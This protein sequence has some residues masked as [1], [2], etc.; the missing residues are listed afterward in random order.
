[1]QEII[2]ELTAGFM[3]DSDK[4]L[5]RMPAEIVLPATDVSDLKVGQPVFLAACGIGKVAA[6]DGGDVTVR[7]A[8]TEKK[9]SA[10]ALVTR[11]QAE[12]NWRA[13]WLP[14]AE[15]R[16]EEGRRLWIVKELCTY[17][18]WQDFLDRFDLSRSTCDDLIRR[19]KNEVMWE[20]QDQHLNGNR[21]S[22]ETEPTTV[23]DPDRHVNERTPD[24]DGDA[25]KELIG[26]E[27]EKR[28]G[29]KPICHKTLWTIRIKLPEQVLTLCRAKYK[30][31]GAKEF[32]RRAAYA[33]VGVDPEAAPEPETTPTP[34][35]AIAGPANCE[36]SPQATPEVAEVRSALR[37][38]GFKAAEVN[39]VQFSPG[40]DFA[41][42]MRIALKQLKATPNAAKKE[43]D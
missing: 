24:P 16:R 19:Y 41:A 36:K 12:V 13:H 2:P 7:F 15:R 34:G 39:K 30:D 14:G 22:D 38:Q 11:A 37:N 21:S 27:A 35:S 43:C 1:M 5:D 26:K 10:Q 31:P 4:D 23:A 42:M 28:H 20:A 29:R 3:R 33:F 32:W 18:E 17:G 6:I 9:V 8:D 25:R 40:L